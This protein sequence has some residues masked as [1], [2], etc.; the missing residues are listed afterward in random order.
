MLEEVLDEFSGKLL[1]GVEMK[2]YAPKWSRRH[3]GTGVARLIRLT[4]SEHDVII[5]SFDFFMLYYLEKEYPGLHS[6][7]AYD[8]SMLGDIGEWFKWVPE[9]GSEISKAPGNQNDISFLNFI[10]ESEVVGRIIGATAVAV[11]HTLIDSDT[12]TKFHD[13]N[14]IVGAYTLYPIDT[15]AVKDDSIDQEK[16]LN[17][18]VDYGVDWIETDDPERVMNLLDR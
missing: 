4:N 7:F 1:M 18:M 10:M 12:V 2:A 5:A 9:I 6:G 11:E 15:H 13:K 14:T 16:V 17:R 3:T 8:D